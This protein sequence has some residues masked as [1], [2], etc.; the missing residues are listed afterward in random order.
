MKN[1]SGLIIVVFFLSFGCTGPDGMKRSPEPISPPEAKILAQTVMA[2]AIESQKLDV[3]KITRLGTIFTDVRSTLMLALAEDPTTVEPVTMNYVKGLEPVY[4]ESIKGL[5]QIF[6]I[7]LRPYTQ[8][9]P[10]GAT[11]AATYIEFVIDGALL[12]CNQAIER[13]NQPA[14]TSLKVYPEEAWPVLK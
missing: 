2:I 8:Q 3:E 4:Q 13:K 11:I 12:A 14:T 5:L 1:L 10:A 7:R 6:I 9:G